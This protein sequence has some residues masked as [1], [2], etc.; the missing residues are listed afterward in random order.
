MLRLFGLAAAYLFLAVISLFF[1]APERTLLLIF[2]PAGLGL[3]ALLLLGLRF[4]PG[5]FIAAVLSGV[6]GGHGGYTALILG[7]LF[8]LESLAACWLLKKTGFNSALQ[9][10]ADFFQ[11]FFLGALA[12]SSIPALGSL[13]LLPFSPTHALNLWL[14]HTL[15]TT[16][17]VS[18]ILVWRQRFWPGNLFK[19]FQASR[20]NP[21]AA[22][23]AVL[24]LG[25]ILAGQTVF[26]DNFASVATGLPLEYMPLIFV[27]WAALRFGRHGVTFLLSL[28]FTQALI[29]TRL[30]TGYFAYDILVGSM[31]NF[32]AFSMALLVTG[33]SLA[34]VI[35]DRNNAEVSAA[36][37]QARVTGL[38]RL[39]QSLSN[40]NQGMLRLTDQAGLFPLACRTIVSHAGMRMAW[41][42]MPT[43]SGHLLEPAACY[44]ES[45]AF[46]DLITVHQGKQSGIRGP[47]AVALHQNRPI[48]INHLS[49]Y[50]NPTHAAHAKGYDYRAT[51][52]FPI[53]RHNKPYAVLTVYSDA[54][55][56]FDDEVVALLKEMSLD[57]SYA[58]EN[59][60]RE[61]Q[62][63]MAEQAVLNSEQRFRAFFSRSMIG[64]ATC[65][66]SGHWLEV[67]DAF[68]QMLHYDRDALL[69]MHWNQFAHPEDVS[70]SNALFNRALRGKID[71]FEIEKRYIRKDG[72]ML[73]AH[74]ALRCIRKEDG[75]INYFACLI[76]DIT[77]SKKTAE[78][79]WKQA[80][81]DQ[82][83]GLIN[84]NLFHDRLQHEIRKSKRTRI[85]LALVYIDLDHF[86]EVNDSMG[87]AAGDAALV[88]AAKRI[89]TCIRAS[90]TLARLG[91]DE[92]VAILGQCPD[93]APVNL[94][95]QKI[96][97]RLSEPFL[98]G[99][100]TIHLTA[101]IG[102]AFYPDDANNMES[103]LSYA[104]Q[105]M[106]ASKHQGRSRFNYF[107]RSMREASQTRQAM[108]KDLRKAVS[109]NQLQ[110]FF[111]PIVDLNSNK[112]V[113]AEA[114]LRWHH[115]S[116]GT[117][118]PGRFIP[119]AEDT[120]M[121]F[122]I[123]DWVFREAATWAR[124]WR[125]YNK[126]GLQISVNKSPMQF[127]VQDT[128]PGQLIHYLNELD[129]PGEHIAIEITEGI[130][131]QSAP[132]VMNKLLRFR[133]AGVQV[134]IDDFGTGY[135]ALSY[136]NKFDIDYLK[137]DQSFIRNI[138]NDPYD[139]ALSEAI[140]VMAHTLGLSV[141]AE[142]VETSAQRDML[143]AAGCD[144][145]QG[146]F[147]SKPISANDF[148]TFLH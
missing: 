101:S 60:E 148:E 49:N 70:A 144:Y 107:T 6:I 124:K 98:I 24:T 71:E 41:I 94:V 141:I 113:K 137:I 1:A 87:H 2:L 118:E 51:G 10:A 58:L 97:Q 8:T 61:N 79:I 77:E 53:R 65:S 90:D 131:M 110:L 93:R 147:F 136:L 119:L 12:A 35:R 105:A 85:P 74:L 128:D 55:Y 73:Y 19:D 81:F 7:C 130:L 106:Y 72:K 11:L 129:L 18:I 75:D 9:N 5:I 111:Q 114:L 99:G 33:M 143:A 47:A 45:A 115:P 142:G 135:S 95:A 67:N 116:L 37:H 139:K 43:D 13:V 32:S 100:K 39:Y 83:T 26:F 123:G 69:N 28:L 38:T 92:F 82:L 36:R 62:R 108:I 122:Q 125:H 20:Y 126:N 78:L 88:E 15:G 103:L 23:L 120:G 138:V 104:D 31:L 44:G 89:G 54:D 56:A 146:Y 132:E 117:I 34:C 66:P 109:G 112:I 42:G 96:I 48:I 102:V 91:G 17:L 22:E 50:P 40:L 140:I 27:V 46:L 145:A 63:R 76:Q 25:T 3:A 80:N 30:G 84:R 16:L 134:A 29:C 14:S 121:I 4:W 68:C 86:K 127:M 59:F 21:R 64:M 57:I 133:N 52:S